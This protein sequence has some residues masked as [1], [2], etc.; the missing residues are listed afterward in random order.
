MELTQLIEKLK[1]ESQ[2]FSEFND[3]LELEYKLTMPVDDNLGKSYPYTS[4]GVIE[5][6]ID[7]LSYNNTRYRLIKEFIQ[8]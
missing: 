6:L 4:E 3:Q 7:R 5:K 2:H 1:I 8:Q